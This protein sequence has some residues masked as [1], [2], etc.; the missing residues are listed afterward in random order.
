[1][2]I[3]VAVNSFKK[4]ESLLY[5]LMT[6]KRVAGDMI[7]TVYINDDCSGD[8]TCRI[9]RHPSVAEY[10]KP[11]TINVREN[12]RNVWVNQAYPRG[13]YPAYMNWKYMLTHWIRFVSPKFE[14][15]KNNIRYQYAIDSTDKKYLYIIH[16]DVKFTGNVP[17][18]YLQSFAK[19]DKCFLVGDL[20]QCWRCRFKDICT[21]Q[22][23]IDGEKPSPYWP[24]TP[25]KKTQDIAAFNPKNGFNMDCRIN[26]W[27]CLVDVEK[28]RAICEKSRA[29][30][31]NYYP[32]AD[33]GAFIFCKGLEYGYTIADPLTDADLRKDY[34]NHGWQ[35]FSGHSVWVNQGQGKAAYDKQ[36]I[37]DLIEKEFGFKW[38]EIGE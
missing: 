21:P 37:I 26:E 17:D 30:F 15:D 20:G 32:R 1:M 25:D 10:F 13:Y 28:L 9:Y 31:G 29:F 18:I 27:S 24:L 14:H 38:P 12:P 8:D 7:D 34:Y 22:K 33:I 36:G 35:G 2:K 5:T 16:D 6:L 23:I 3:D 11:W 4:P 19:D